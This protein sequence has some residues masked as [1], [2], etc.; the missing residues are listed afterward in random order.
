MKTLAEAL[1][2]TT[3]PTTAPAV[4]E[5]QPRKFRV[6]LCAQ[7]FA[8]LEVTAL[9]PEAAFELANARRAE[10]TVDF[11]TVLSPFRTDV[12]QPIDLRDISKGFKW[13]RY[14]RQFLDA[15][16]WTKGQVWAIGKD[17]GAVS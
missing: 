1:A 8:V 4:A 7:K 15:L 3:A 13:V 14:E 10:A 11:V 9:T 17:A 2:E 12:L 16:D 5:P 6:H